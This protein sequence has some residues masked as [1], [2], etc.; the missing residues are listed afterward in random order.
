MRYFNQSKNKISMNA[1]LINPNGKSVKDVCI[2]AW[3]ENGE[4]WPLGGYDGKE[5]TEYAALF[6][7]KTAAVSISLEY[8]GEFVVVCK[9][10]GRVLAIAG[11]CFM[12]LA[13]RNAVSRDPSL[14]DVARMF[15]M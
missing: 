10:G 14:N 1:V 6:A 15:D 4:A 2:Y 11:D 8:S 7:A 12:G 3:Y 13:M 5:M 9:A